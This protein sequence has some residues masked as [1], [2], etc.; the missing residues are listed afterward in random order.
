MELNFSALD[1]LTGG[2][3]KQSKNL[4]TYYPSETQ[5][6]PDGE[7][8]PSDAM[9][10]YTTLEAEQ[11]RAETTAAMYREYQE[12]IKRSELLRAEITKGIQEG[13]DVYGLLLK[14]LEAI[15]SMTGDKVFFEANKEALL[16]V[17]GAL[18]H[19][20]PITHSTQE[21]QRRLDRL[22]AAYEREPEYT[23]RRRIQTAI[24]AHRKKLERLQSMKTE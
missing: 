14:A 18:G 12:N 23:T 8:A 19:D 21:V 20:A 1:R 3:D 6:A 4:E 7:F 9:R 13:A 16:S 15:S 2:A 11:H 5:N 24:D 17:Y 10:R 22:C